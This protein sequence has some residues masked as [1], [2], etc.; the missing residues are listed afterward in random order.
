MPQQIGA[1]CIAGFAYVT[2]TAPADFARTRYMTAR[3]VA[4][5]TGKQVEFTSGIDVIHRTVRTQGVRA[6]YAGFFPQWA[7]AAPYTTIQILVWEKLSTLAGMST[8]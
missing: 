4:A 1:S 8:V 2:T 5:Q 3:Q 6:L 7:R